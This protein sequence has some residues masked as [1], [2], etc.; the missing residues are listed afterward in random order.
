MSKPG[1]EGAKR[2]PDSDA[3]LA[4]SPEAVA[5]PHAPDKRGVVAVAQ[6]GDRYLAIRRGREV[7]APGRVCFPGGHVEPGEEEHA[8]VVRECREE[9]RAHV[10]A[11]ECVWRSV[12]PWG[13]ALSWWTVELDPDATLVPHPI[14]VEAI[15]WLTID[16]LLAEPTLLEGNREF[17]LQARK[18]G[19]FGL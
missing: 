14:E 4:G 3:S 5:V 13:T 7:A 6:R 19:H 16:E 1:R 8:A 11:L 12:T 18:A 17:L 9:L 2:R 15:Y 10:A